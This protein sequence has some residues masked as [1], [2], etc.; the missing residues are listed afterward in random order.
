MR[1]LKIIFD[2][3]TDANKINEKVVQ[4]KDEEK[5]ESPVGALFSMLGDSL[6][7]KEKVYK[8]KKSIKSRKEI[9]KLQ[10]L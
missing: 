8:T 9:P 6:E 7:K 1:N 2:P 3:R 4:L 10:F 5:I